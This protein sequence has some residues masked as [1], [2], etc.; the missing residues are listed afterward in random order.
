MTTRELA[1][2]LREERGGVYKACRR[3]EEAGKL[4]SELKAAGNL[5]F[6]RV[7]GE[8]INP[9]NAKRIHEMQAQLRGLIR[10]YPLPQK[11]AALEQA[12]RAYFRGLDRHEDLKRHTRAMK[13]FEVRIIEA[14]TK[15]GTTTDQLLALVDSIPIT[16]MERVW[17]LS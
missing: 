9:T 8:T 16:R 2:H 5:Y 6:F 10:N 3:L 13:K 15:Q 11:A 7:T 17:S 1:D 12:L 14:V 4:V